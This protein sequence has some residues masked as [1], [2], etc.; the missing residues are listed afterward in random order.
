MKV[1]ASVVTARRKTL[2]ALLEDHR[3]LP[4]AEVCTRLKISEATARRDL[5]VLEREQRITRT[6][7][8]ALSTFDATSAS[9]VERRMLNRRAKARIAEKALQFIRP[10]SIC[11]FD[12]GTTIFALAEALCRKPVAALRAVTNNLPV[13]EMLGRCADIE[14]H[15]LGGRFFAAPVDPARRGCVPIGASVEIRY[16]LPRR[17]RNHHEWYLGQRSRGGCLPAYPCAPVGADLCL[18]ARGEVLAVPRE[19]YWGRGVHN[20]NSSPMPRWLNLTATAFL[21]K[22]VPLD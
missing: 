10:G 20:F 15:L 11:F 6:Y 9:F 7:G 12:S 2:S 22:A 13:A 21:S 3:Y 1:A 8:G 19:F 5:R 16:G 17:G 18:R 14:V 4:L